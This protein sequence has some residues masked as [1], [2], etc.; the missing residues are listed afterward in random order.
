MKKSLFLILLLSG[1]AQAQ[2][3][4]SALKKGNHEVGFRTFSVYDSARPAVM[5]QT[6]K[7]KGR[8]LQLNVWYPARKTKAKPLN[9]NDYVQ[10][11]GKE[12][13]PQ[14]PNNQTS[15]N[16]YFD[17][18]MKEGAKNEDIKK[19]KAT[20]IKMWAS[21]EAVPA[22]INA[23]V[24][25]LMH[26]KAADFAFLGE[27]LASH[28]FVAIHTPYKGYAQ[29]ELDVSLLGMDTQ[30]TDY[31]FAVATLKTKVN[32][33]FSKISVL[34]VSF[35]GQSAVAYT[36]RNP[37]QAV[38]SFDGGIG[39]QWGAALLTQTKDYQLKNIKT[40]LLHLFNPRDQYTHLSAIR[41]YSYCDR[42]LIGMKNREH[43]H[44][45]AWG[46]LDKFIPNAL[47]AARP[48]QSYEAVLQMTLDFLNKYQK[49]LPSA[50]ALAW[51]NACRSSAEEMKVGSDKNS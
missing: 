36:F 51:V 39:S 3:P 30:V 15:L 17:W 37:V 38:V 29:A 22:V 41:K 44:F 24:V 35:G 12:I 28:G 5:E 9:F 42:T 49:G 21:Q 26:G 11:S 46:V 23:P 45:W 1:F 10:L 50:T 25:L 16:D 13:N 4:F 7:S 2:M 19:F 43:A 40:P 27:F 34:G 32:A 18:T 48:G 6:E 14:S 8:V 31:E 20:G 47:G 33:D